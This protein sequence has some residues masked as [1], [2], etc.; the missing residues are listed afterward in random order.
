MDL[1]DKYLQ[2]YDFNEVHRTIIDAPPE[3]IYRLAQDLD[4]SDSWIIQM[5]FFL[6]GL[7]AKEISIK[8][9]GDQ[10]FTILE[11]V[12]NKEVM[13]GL[14]GEFWKP[15]GN[16]QFFTAET[17]STFKGPYAKATWNFMLESK[18]GKT[19]LSTETRI[20]CPDPKT[21]KAF[22]RYWFVIGPFS[23]LIR[24][25]MLRAIRVKAERQV[26]QLYA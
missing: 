5:L 21:K 8:R 4:F 12:P 23:G 19:V 3:V 26:R 7:P 25:E 16:L 11:E 6:R 2:Q 18:E 10:K 15:S 9:L 20:A 13:I 22:A 1:H 14:I 24:K 17:F